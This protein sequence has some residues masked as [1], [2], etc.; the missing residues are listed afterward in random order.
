MNIPRDLID[1]MISIP[2][3]SAKFIDGSE[4][5]NRIGERSPVFDEWIKAKCGSF[6]DV[7]N[8][9]LEILVSAD[10]GHVA[11][12]ILQENKT[13]LTQQKIQDLERWV[14][15]SKYAKSQAQ[16]MSEGYRNYLLSEQKKALRAFPW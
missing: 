9:D 12:E 15:H 2:S 11:E 6:S 7:E 5:E 10:S 3:S 14:E 13:Q 4:I 8:K 16:K 1:D